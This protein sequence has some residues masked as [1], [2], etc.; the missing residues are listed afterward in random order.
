MNLRSVGITLAGLII[1]AGSAH[2]ARSMLAPSAD[3]VH[4]AAPG[5]SVAMGTV[6]VALRDMVS[7]EPV[8]PGSVAVRAWPQDSIPEGAFRTLDEVLGAAESGPRSA[9]REIAA[10]ELLLASRV[11]DF[12]E[13]VTILQSLAPGHRA[14]T[15]EVDAVSGV[16]GF[17][18]PG[19][20]VDIV[21]TETESGDL[22]ARTIMQR[23]RVIGV[24]QALDAGVAADADRIAGTIT[25]EVT[26]QDGQKLAL[27]QRA[28]RLSLTLGAAT[29]EVA[30]ALPALS[31]S[32]LLG[33]VAPQPEAAADPAAP[34][35]RTVTVRRGS[36]TEVVELPQ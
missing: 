20:F 34:P 33:D 18:T 9:R 22:R 1:A 5:P 12:G 35:R 2:V 31:L 13:K 6:V 3:A 4:F 29:G 19:D 8:L 30:E 17:V 14:M 32:E 23:V 24:D 25:V 16:A 36:E 26:P 11:S 7:G 10:G 15:I 28:G 21:L 27:A